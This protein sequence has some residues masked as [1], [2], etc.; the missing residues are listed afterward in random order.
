MFDGLGGNVLE[1]VVRDG[2]CHLRPDV[3]QSRTG[4]ASARDDAACDQTGNRVADGIGLERHVRPCS[5]AHTR[6]MHLARA[7][8]LRLARALRRR[9]PFA[10]RR[11]AQR[12]CRVPAASGDPFVAS[13]IRVSLPGRFSLLLLPLGLFG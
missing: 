1:G 11:P 3:L 13:S 12:R 2:R 5:V 10:C 6:E 4:G 9:R 8:H 7:S